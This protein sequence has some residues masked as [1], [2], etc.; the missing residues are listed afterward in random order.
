MIFIKFLS[1][2]ILLH[3]EHVYCMVYEDT[4]NTFALKLDKYVDDYYLFIKL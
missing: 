3:Q 1:Y 4:G 2:L